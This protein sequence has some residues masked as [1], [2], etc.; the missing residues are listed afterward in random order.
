VK[1]TTLVCITWIQCCHFHRR[2]KTT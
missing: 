2:T 1:L